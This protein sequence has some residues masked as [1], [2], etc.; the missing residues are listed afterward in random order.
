M[1]E[2]PLRGERIHDWFGSEPV[3]LGQSDQAL[4]QVLQQHVQVADGAEQIAKPF[5]LAYCA[6]PIRWWRGFHQPKSRAWSLPPS[7]AMARMSRWLGWSKRRCVQTM[8]AF[9]PLK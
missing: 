4:L 9:S 5:E 1:R 8:I 7:I 3:V 2:L 6:L